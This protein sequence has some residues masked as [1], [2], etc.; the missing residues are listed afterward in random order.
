MSNHQKA[1]QLADLVKQF[2]LLLNSGSLDLSSEATARSWIEE[3]LSIFN[4]NCR[5]PYEVDQEVSLTGQE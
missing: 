1:K 3:L 4:W 2:H 5:D